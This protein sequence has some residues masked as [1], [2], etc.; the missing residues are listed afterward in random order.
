[1]IRVN[2]LKWNNQIMT[3]T[4]DK[5]EGHPLSNLY[6]VYTLLFLLFG[7]IIFAALLVRHNSFVMSGDCFN[8]TYPTLVFLSHWYRRILPNLF[9]G[10]TDL[11]SMRIGFG[12]DVIGALN[13]FGCMDIF[14]FLCVL[15]PERLMS[16]AFTLI[17]LL[18]FYLGGMAFLFYTR[19]KGLTRCASLFG[20]LMYA[21]S[22]YA[23]GMGLIAFNFSTIMVWFPLIICSLDRLLKQ[24]QEGTVKISFLFILT[25][26]FLSLTGFYFLYMAALAAVLYYLAEGVCRIRGGLLSGNSFLHCFFWILLHALVGVGL[27]SIV[28]LPVFRQYLTGSRTK[29]SD[30]A[31][32]KLLALPSL[33]DLKN[34]V[35]NLFLPADSPYEQGEGWLILTIFIVLFLFLHARDKKYGKKILFVLLAAFGYLFPQVGLIMNGMAYSTNRWTFITAFFMS[36]LTASMAEDLMRDYGRRDLVADIIVGIVLFAGYVVLRG[37]GK[38]TFIRVGIFGLLWAALVFLLYHRNGK[39]RRKRIYLLSLCNVVLLGFFLFAPVAIGGSGVGASFRALNFVS[40]E[41]HESA[42]G[43]QCEV[44]QNVGGIYRYDFND[45]SLDASLALDCNTTY[46]YYSMC[47]GSLIHLMEELRISPAIMESFTLQGLDGRKALEALLSVRMYAVSNYPLA[48]MDNESMIPFGFTCSDAVSEDTI[49]D[50]NPLQKMNTLLSAAVI[51]D[52][53]DEEFLTG[54]AE[55][56]TQEEVPCEVTYGDGITVHGDTI[57]AKEGSSIRLTFDPV[58]LEESGKELYLVIDHLIADSSFKYDIDV[59]GRYIRILDRNREWFYNG[60][61]SYVINVSDLAPTGVVELTFE[62]TAAYE[63]SGIHL[64]VNNPGD[65]LR[66]VADRSAHT[67]ENVTFEHD[68]LQGN[69]SVPSD[70]WLVVT[71]PYSE[72]FTCMIDGKETDIAKADYAFMTVRVPAGDH[73]IVFHYC[74]PWLRKGAMMSLLSL[75][76][77]IVWFVLVRKNLCRTMED[78]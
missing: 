51:S 22:F 55:T 43:R 64:F 17:T 20:S 36:L 50:M 29:N 7:G 56:G 12:D 25:L 3:I 27:G 58:A 73:K 72:G 11:Y 59:A 39:H 18:R 48:I 46:V 42:L 54:T 10:Q 8:Q 45:T 31:L 68:T 75:G 49:E 65:F 71:L 19:E 62:D 1:M 2:R 67:L 16:Y 44:D 76:I 21:Y 61:Y 4:A 26:F 24:A 6:M 74:T 9:R 40:S 60:D 13:W 69:L 38:Q 35:E 41:I 47:N 23:L 33:D 52:E 15:F 77:L 63:L 14:T 5:K 28:L 32:L 34:A 78:D 70:Q 30:G 37:P 53:N 57:D 66:K